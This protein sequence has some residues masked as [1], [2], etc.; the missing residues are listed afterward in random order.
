MWPEPAT[1][2]PRVYSKHH[3]PEDVAISEIGGIGMDTCDGAD[4]RRSQSEGGLTGGQVGLGY[5]VVGF[6]EA[7]SEVVAPVPM[8]NRLDQLVAGIHNLVYPT[9]AVVANIYHLQ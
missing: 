6:L 5:F 1:A 7:V 2:P 9:E 8:V 4:D 3:H